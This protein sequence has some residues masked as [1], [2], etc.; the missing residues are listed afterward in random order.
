MIDDFINKLKQMGSK[1][2][3]GNI[4]GTISQYKQYAKELQQ[5]MSGALKS[6]GSDTAKGFEQQADR[7]KMLCNV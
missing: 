7:I 5:A 3:L 4:S 2:G 1:Q 6:S